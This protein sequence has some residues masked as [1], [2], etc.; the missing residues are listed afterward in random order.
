LLHDDSDPAQRTFLFPTPAY[1]KIA[2]AGTNPAVI[3]VLPARHWR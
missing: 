3:D 1:D 2:V